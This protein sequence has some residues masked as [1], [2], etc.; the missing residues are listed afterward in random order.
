MNITSSASS[1]A[2]IFSA[3]LAEPHVQSGPVLICAVAF[4]HDHGE[5]IKSALRLRA[6][7]RG[8]EVLALKQA[9]GERP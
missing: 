6:E 9:S 1:L 4:G 3:L 2:D 8:K 5:L 7:R